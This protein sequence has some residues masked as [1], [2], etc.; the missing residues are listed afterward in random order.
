MNFWRWVSSVASMVVLGFASAGAEVYDL[1]KCIQ[2]ALENNYGVISSRNA[3][4]AARWNVWSGYGR[5][6]PRISISV[7]RNRSWFPMTQSTYY[8]NGIPFTSS[9]GGARI[10]YGSD[11]N[12]GQ[13]FAGLG[14]G[15]YADIRQK[16]AQKNYYYYSY[17]DARRN[18]VLGVK[19]AYFNVVKARLL[20]EVAQQAVKRG[21]E[22][23]KV[24]QTRY[25]LGSASFSD[26]LK[27]R[28]LRSNAKVDLVTAENNLNLAKANLNYILGVEITRDI[29]VTED[30][31]E[32]DLQ[33]TYDG[34]LAEALRNNAELLRTKY[35]LDIAKMNLLNAKAQ[36]LPALSFNLRYSNA[37]DKFDELMD[38][39]GSNSS[40]GFGVALTYSIFN[41]FSDMAGWIAQRKLVNTQKRG[42]SDTENAIALEVKQAFLNVQQ[43]KEKLAL[44]RESVAAAQEDLNIVKEKYNLGAA[45]IIEVLDAEVSYKQ[46]QVGQVQA[47][48]DYNLAI[49]RLEK[50][51]GRQE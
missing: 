9:Q 47:L 43:G 18:L 10:N 17:I 34:A 36:F 49:S 51:M 24:A 20:V 3:Y 14:L 48:F 23:L 40:S 8:I 4:D 28:V 15:L 19:E 7:D 25:D 30:F 35:D 50:T 27:A 38:F 37:A 2:T 39:R 5:I 46:A 1:A 42:L 6:L 31:Q 22:Q 32:P 11:L 16:H 12:I 44:N 45:T 26:V 13:S 21:E 29:E 33:I 41:N